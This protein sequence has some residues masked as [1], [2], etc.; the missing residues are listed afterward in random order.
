MQSLK[1]LASI[2][3]GK[4]DNILKFFSKETIC[5]LSP[6]N[7]RNNNKKLRYIHDLLNVI[8]NHTKSEL[9]WIRT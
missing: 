7:I 5:Q 1:D 3:S 2:V 6:L 8:N 9:N 4:K